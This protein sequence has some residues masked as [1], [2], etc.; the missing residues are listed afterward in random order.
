VKQFTWAPYLGDRARQDDRLVAQIVH[1]ARADAA[2]ELA[3]T[4]LAGLADAGV[5]PEPDLEPFG[6]GL[7]GRDLG[8]A[9]LGVAPV[10]AVPQRH[11]HA[12]ARRADR[13]AGRTSGLSG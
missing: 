6:V 2:L 12:R 13:V 3:P 10:H 11:G 9:L 7:R 8:E 4:H 5:V 1:A